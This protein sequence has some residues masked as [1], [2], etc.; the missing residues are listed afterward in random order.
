MNLGTD[1]S[2]WN[3]YP[4]RAEAGVKDC[5]PRPAGAGFFKSAQNVRLQCGEPFNFLWVAIFEILPQF[6]SNFLRKMRKHRKIF[7]YWPRSCKVSPE[8]YTKIDF[9]N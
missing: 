7:Y 4:G 3:F 2:G 6:L 9:L 1:R 5:Q 8:N